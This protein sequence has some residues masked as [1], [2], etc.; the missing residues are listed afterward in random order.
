LQGGIWVQSR[1]GEGA[2]FIVEL[3]R[4]RRAATPPPPVVEAR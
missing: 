2:T 1:V 3:P 4:Q